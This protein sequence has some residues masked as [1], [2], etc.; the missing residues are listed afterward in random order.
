[1]KN[2]TLTLIALL[3]IINISSQITNVDTT[4]LINYQSQEVVYLDIDNDVDNLHDIIIT[5]E[6]SQ[7]N[8]I[9]VNAGGEIISIQGN[10][11]VKTCQGNIDENLG[12]NND[13]GYTRYYNSIYAIEGMYNIPFRIFR[14]DTAEDYQQHRYKYGYLSIS[15]LANKDMV[16]NGWHINNTWDEG[17]PCFDQYVSIKEKAANKGKGPF[18]CYDMRGRALDKNNLPTNQIVIRVYSNGFREKFIKQFNQ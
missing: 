10:E 14:L 11:I 17:I 9:G 3:A 2:L 8:S 1:M 12:W 5:N 7:Y 15:I 6:G 16:V 13:F 4:I 18:I